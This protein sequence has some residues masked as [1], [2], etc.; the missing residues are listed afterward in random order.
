[1]SVHV[2][3][4]YR[5]NNC[6]SVFTGDDETIALAIFHIRVNSFLPDNYLVTKINA[7]HREW[8]LQLFPG[9]WS[10]IELQSNNPQKVLKQ[11]TITVEDES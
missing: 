3:K 4:Y 8:I 10:W 7:E 2:I 1:M 9:G 11:V 5:N 6:V